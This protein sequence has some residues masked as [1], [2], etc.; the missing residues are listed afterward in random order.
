MV[1]EN[2]VVR[3][4]QCWANRYELTLLAVRDWGPCNQR[5]LSLRSYIGKTSLA[6]VQ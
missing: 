1:V 4:L 5:V 2:R 3:V 6:S